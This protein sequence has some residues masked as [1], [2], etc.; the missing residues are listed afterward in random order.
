MV[1]TSSLRA[2][3]FACSCYTMI[4][5][6]IMCKQGHCGSFKSLFTR[7]KSEAT[8]TQVAPAIP[9]PSLANL[10]SFKVAMSISPPQICKQAGVFDHFLTLTLPVIFSICITELAP[11]FHQWQVLVYISQ[12]VLEK[13][14]IILKN[15]CFNYSPW[16]AYV[17][18]RGRL[19]LFSLPLRFVTRFLPF[20]FLQECG[21]LPAK[22]ISRV[23]QQGSF[24]KGIYFCLL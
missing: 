6:G 9:F 10:T 3:A 5:L 12:K 21:F 17:Y 1:T 20:L 24:L 15:L 16:C 11:D 4:S 8:S 7:N 18:L 19:G 14:L 2:Y 22:P 23:S 13:Y